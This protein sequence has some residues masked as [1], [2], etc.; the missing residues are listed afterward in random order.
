MS[1]ILRNVETR[2]RKHAR[3]ALYRVSTRF[4]EPKQFDIGVRLSIPV[5]IPLLVSFTIWPHP[6]INDTVGK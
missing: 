6:E 4:S 5:G 3:R 1:L 2:S